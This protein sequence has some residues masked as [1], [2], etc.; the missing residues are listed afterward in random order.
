LRTAL[1]FMRYGSRALDN[2][3]K[4]YQATHNNLT[5]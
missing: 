2:Y 4:Y 1:F 3:S 5:N